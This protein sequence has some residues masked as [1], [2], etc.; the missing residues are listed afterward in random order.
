MLNPMA[1][2]DAAAHA[3]TAA[4]TSSGRGAILP[5][6]AATR[7]LR[8]ETGTLRMRPRVSWD[9]GLTGQRVEAGP[10]MPGLGGLGNQPMPV[11]QRNPYAQCNPSSPTKQ[12]PYT[13]RFAAPGG[14]V[15][16]P[17]PARDPV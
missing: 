11:G 14:D 10:S 12:F 17:H 3:A 7:Q 4:G 13:T 1:A 16:G 6:A 15:K 2:L 5:S 8:A 9:A